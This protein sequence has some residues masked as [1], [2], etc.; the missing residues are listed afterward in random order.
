MKPLNII[1]IIFKTVV[2]CVAKVLKITQHKLCRMK[3]SSKSKYKCFRENH[4]STTHTF[5]RKAHTHKRKKT[6]LHKIFTLIEVQF[7]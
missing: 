6:C 7:R 5:V 1:Y 3:L 2:W 4:R